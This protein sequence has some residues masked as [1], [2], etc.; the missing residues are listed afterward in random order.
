M[1]RFRDYLDY[2][3]SE[4]HHIAQCPVFGPAVSR[5]RLKIPCRRRSGVGV[6]VSLVRDTLLRVY[7][8][9]V[10][11]GGSKIPRL[12]QNGYSLGERVCN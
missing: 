9:T 1:A 5:L 6:A 12:T 4:T 7:D 10:E 8:E 2:G 11:S 3:M